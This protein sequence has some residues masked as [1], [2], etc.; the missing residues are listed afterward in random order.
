MINELFLEPQVSTSY[1]YKERYPGP[2]CGQ[3]ALLRRLK[4]PVDMYSDALIK[5]TSQ[6]L[7]MFNVAFIQRS[8]N[9]DL[10]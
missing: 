8:D 2:L 1:N 9:I 7:F 5:P 10:P 3:G 6:T 4:D